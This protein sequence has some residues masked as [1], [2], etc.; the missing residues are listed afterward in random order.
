MTPFKPFL[1]CFDRRELQ[2]L[3]LI[4]GI[5]RG[6]IQAALKEL[7]RARTATAPVED[8]VEPAIRRLTRALAYDLER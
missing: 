6:E 7:R 3:A 2:R 4:E 8:C 1:A 5:L